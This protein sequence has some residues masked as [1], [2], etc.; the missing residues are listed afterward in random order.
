MVSKGQLQEDEIVSMNDL[1]RVL[2]PDDS[3]DLAAF[4]SL[5]ALQ[6]PV[7]VIDQAPGKFGALGVDTT[8]RISPFKGPFN[9]GDTCR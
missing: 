8:D 1:V 3:L 9:G 4:P 7:V 5:D 6:F 2:I